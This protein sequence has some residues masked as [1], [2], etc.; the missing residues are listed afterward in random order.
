MPRLFS[1]GTLRQPDVQVATFGR[2]L[3]GRPDELVGYA[4]SVATI[5]DPASIAE[6]GDTHVN[7]APTGRADDRV[8]GMVFEV[9]D[10]ELA[11][12][13]DYEAPAGYTRAQARLASGADAWVYLQPA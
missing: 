11:C 12:A 7:V 1:Y 4:R 10:T 8:N 6:L 3:H 2:R 5:T 13:D 9:T